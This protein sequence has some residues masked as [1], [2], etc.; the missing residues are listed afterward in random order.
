MKNL[1]TITLLTFCAYHTNAQYV[2]FLGKKNII[3]LDAK[4][5][6][7]LFYNYSILEETRYKNKSDGGKLSPAKNILDFG[8]NA[9][10]G[11]S[12]SNGFGLALQYSSMTYDIIAHDLNGSDEYY[13]VGQD[14]SGYDVTGYVTRGSFMKART[15]QF[16]PTIEFCGG[17]GLLPVGLVHQLGIGFG[18]SSLLKKEY[19]FEARESSYYGNDKTVRKTENDIDESVYAAQFNVTSI[20][21]KISLRIPITKSILYNIGLRYNINFTKSEYP[22]FNNQSTSVL[23]KFYVSQLIRQREFRGLSVFET[24]ISFVF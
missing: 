18:K 14:T 16:M 11:H 2:G 10:I 24:G 1:I 21:Y 4:I 9:T 6:A 7:P 5:T 15:T 8:F 17:G 20:M 22:S 13:Y 23:S 19:A 3:S 12:F